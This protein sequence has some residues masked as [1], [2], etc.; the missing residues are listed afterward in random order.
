MSY[1]RMALVRPD[2]LEKNNV[3]KVSTNPVASEPPLDA[4]RQ[5][6][7]TQLARE[8]LSPTAS[9]VQILSHLQKSAH[10]VLNDSTLHSSDKLR[11]FNQ[12]MVKSSILMD[13]ARMSGRAAIPTAQRPA[14]GRP[15]TSL[16]NKKRRRFQEEDSDDD[17][18][19]VEEPLE[20]EPQDTSEDEWAD[21][22]SRTPTRRRSLEGAVGGASSEDETDDMTMRPMPTSTTR[23]MDA[24]I[25]RH[26]PGTYQG[27]V[28][29]LYRLLAEKGQ[30]RE[31]NWTAKGELVV[32][33]KLI[34]G[35]NLL[36][37]LTDAARKKSRVKPPIGRD[38]F[39]KIVKRLNP[40]LKHVKNKS[41]FRVEGATSPR[42]PSR[43]RS[44][45]MSRSRSRPRSRSKSRGRS[46]TPGNKGRRSA[47]QI[48]SGK[49]VAFTWRT[50]L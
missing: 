32:G 28:K 37:L 3:D 33:G 14:G 27:T 4:Q 18:T 1:T 9:L 7:L 13:K 5:Y 25:M 45:S 35:T 10:D 34:P 8:R 15:I 40:N 39:V 38:V 29:S 31:F 30:G 12:I 22:S 24:D 21:S 17:D 20:H 11:Q 36:E 46:V 6:Y 44:T 26:V 50:K 41:V 43:H 16:V 49:R 42:T 23:D 47:Q 19:D 2:L 48:G